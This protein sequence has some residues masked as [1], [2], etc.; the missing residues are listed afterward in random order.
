MTGLGNLSEMA[1]NEDE[2]GVLDEPE[3][4]D[5]G[6]GEVG[7]QWVPVGGNQCPAG[8]EGV[9]F[10]L[11]LPHQLEETKTK[12]VALQ[13]NLD[14]D[15]TNRNNNQGGENKGKKPGS[16]G[17]WG[18]KSAPFP[19]TPIKQKP[20]KNGDVEMDEKSDLSSSGSDRLDE[21]PSLADSRKSTSFRR[22]NKVE[23]SPVAP[24]SSS[25]SRTSWFDKPVK[26]KKK[27]KKDKKGTPPAA[28]EQLEEVTDI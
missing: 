18:Q 17:M 24:A 20:N 6:Y 7:T 26:N 16:N 14:I 12:K 27:K 3:N 10:A 8:F 22:S 2:E 13:R 25:K 15:K 19:V 11:K 28:V 23:P 5:R 9:E 21:I 4:G 1:E